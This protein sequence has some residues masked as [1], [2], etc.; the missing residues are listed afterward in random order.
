[1]RMRL[2]FITSSRIFTA[3]AAAS[4]S[5]SASASSSSSSSSLELEAK[6]APLH[7]RALYMHPPYRKQKRGIARSGRSRHRSRRTP[8]TRV[9]AAAER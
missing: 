8:L 4:A 2:L 9:S 1:M 6:Q 7:V 5:A 3:S